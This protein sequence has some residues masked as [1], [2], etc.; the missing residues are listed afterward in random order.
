MHSGLLGFWLELLVFPRHFNPMHTQSTAQALEST[1]K[2]SGC[3]AWLDKRK[4]LWVDVVLVSFF[5]VCFTRWHLASGWK[6]NVALQPK[7]IP[8]SYCRPGNSWV[9]ECPS[10]SWKVGCSIHSHRVNCRSAP[11][12]RAFTSTAPARSTVQAPAC[13]QLPSPNKKNIRTQCF[14][15]DSREPF[16][17]FLHPSGTCWWRQPA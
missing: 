13:R 11:W 15:L 17:E 10:L 16:L 2:P 12:A 5:F 7:P 14:R 3:C 1:R 4:K 8:Q 6:L 9:V